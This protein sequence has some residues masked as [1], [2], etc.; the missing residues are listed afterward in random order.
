MLALRHW[1]FNLLTI[2]SLVLALAIA[3]VWFFGREHWVLLEWT[4]QNG[5]AGVELIDS[6]FDASYTNYRH[7]RFP[8]PEGWKPNIGWRFMHRW[9]GPK[10]GMS[11]V[12]KWR[13]FPAHYTYARCHVEYQGDDWF[14]RGWDFGPFSYHRKAN[15]GEEP[16]PDGPDVCWYKAFLFPAWS[17]L[18]ILGLLPALSCKRRL[19]Q[20]RQGRRSLLGLCGTCGYDLRATPDRCPECGTPAPV[21]Q[22]SSVRR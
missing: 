19:R 3:V 22:G 13:S 2:L 18:P 15:L 10:A 5:S 16:T 6:S 20:R 17:V 8:Q 21:G 9:V 1:A 14:V 4:T 7:E 11:G 12:L